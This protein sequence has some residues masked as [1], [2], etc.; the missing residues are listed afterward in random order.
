MAAQ[1]GVDDPVYPILGFTRL[2][3]AY[4]VGLQLGLFA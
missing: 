4:F 2:V 1:T 3:V